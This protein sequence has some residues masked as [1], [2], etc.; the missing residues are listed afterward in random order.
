MLSLP[1][2]KNKTIK[3]IFATDIT[4][5]NM[6][7]L[8]EACSTSPLSTSATFLMA[9]SI[10]SSPDFD[11]DW[12]LCLNYNVIVLFYYVSL[13]LSSDSGSVRWLEHVRGKNTPLVEQL[14]QQRQLQQSAHGWKG[15]VY[16]HWTCLR[17]HHSSLTTTL[18][19][20]TYDALPKSHTGRKGKHCEG[21]VTFSSHRHCLNAGV[22]HRCFAWPT[23][24]SLGLQEM[25][26]SHSMTINLTQADRRCHLKHG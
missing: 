1:N 11:F 14:G 8:L 19:I 12:K 3:R 5:S 10:L 22:W 24:V 26:L 18:E 4:S 16:S 17:P 20:S 7:V 6:S 15:F 2:Q 9:R 25:A 23:P 21:P 13:T